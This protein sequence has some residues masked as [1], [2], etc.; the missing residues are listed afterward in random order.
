MDLLKPEYNIRKF[1]ASNLGCRWKL[2]E[3]SKT[4]IS[5]G[6]K[7]IKKSKKHLE[8]ISKALTG[9]VLSEETK[10]KISNSK[11]GK[12]WTKARRNAQIV[13]NNKN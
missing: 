6:M 1:A 8:N 10:L 5:K 3:D 4:N 12:P 11:K 13:L 7:K 9:R 2:G